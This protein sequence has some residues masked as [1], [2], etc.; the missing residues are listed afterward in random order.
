M[1]Y[2]NSSAFRCTEHLAVQSKAQ[3]FLL[4]LCEATRVP[5]ERT[6]RPL[7]LDASA[8]PFLSG[9]GVY[10]TISSFHGS[11]MSLCQGAVQASLML[12]VVFRS[13]LIPQVHNLG[14]HLPRN[15]LCDEMRSSQHPTSL[16]G[17][18]CKLRASC[19]KPGGSYWVAIRFQAIDIINHLVLF[20][21]SFTF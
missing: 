17:P 19:C 11:L 6:L 5:P 9:L 2:W 12:S 1:N 8:P 15:C 4:H 13:S 7:P 21:K 10:K 14:L 18:H 20:S 3:P 16:C